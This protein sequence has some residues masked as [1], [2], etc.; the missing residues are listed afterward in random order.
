MP[1]VCTHLC[2]FLAAEAVFAG[3]GFIFTTLSGNMIDGWVCGCMNLTAV[4]WRTSFSSADEWRTRKKGVIKSRG[5]WQRNG[6]VLCV[7]GYEKR[8]CCSPSARFTFTI[9]FNIRCDSDFNSNNCI[10]VGAPI[11]NEITYI[12]RK[13]GEGTRRHGRSY[14]QQGES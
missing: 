5:S 13:W 2:I 14:R 11:E 10:F 1:V 6:L 7:R 12:F 8:L 9:I 3:C 4:S